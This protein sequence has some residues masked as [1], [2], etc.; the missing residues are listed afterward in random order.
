MTTMTIAFNTSIYAGSQYVGFPFNSY[1]VFAGKVLAAGPEGIYEVGTGDTDNGQP[2]E[3]LIEFAKSGLGSDKPKHVRRYLLTG[4]S[5]GNLMLTVRADDGPGIPHPVAVRTPN[6]YSAMFEPGRR[7]LRGVYF[8]VS[9]ENLNGCR[10]SLDS[11]TLEVVHTSRR[12]T[13]A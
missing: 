2:I 9:L 7:D 3:A 12:E 5:S 13:P 8:H 10:F 11:M 1:C 6:R 4:K